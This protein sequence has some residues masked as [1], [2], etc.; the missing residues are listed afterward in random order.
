MFCQSDT[1]VVGDQKGRGCPSWERT[2]RWKARHHSDSHTK[3]E[4][5]RV[6]KAGIVKK[7]ET[8]SKPSNGCPLSQIKSQNSSLWHQGPTGPATTLPF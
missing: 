5:Q 2:M 6:M 4:I 1:Q 3:A 7:H 8:L